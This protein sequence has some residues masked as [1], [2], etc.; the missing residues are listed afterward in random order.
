[1]DVNGWPWSRWPAETRWCPTWSWGRKLGFKD[2]ADCKQRIERMIAAEKLSDVHVV[3]AVRETR[4]PTGGIRRTE[5]TEYHLT[6]AQALK[7]IAKSETA[8]ADEAVAP[9]W[10]KG[11]TS[12]LEAVAQDGKKRMVF[13]LEHPAHKCENSRQRR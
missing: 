1:M 13:C 10:A 8:I 6:E 12:N 4:M 9:I 5:V 2:P 11:T 7:V 3:L